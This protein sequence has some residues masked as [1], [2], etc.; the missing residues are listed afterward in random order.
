MQNLVSTRTRGRACALAVALVCAAVASATTA[1][2][3]NVEATCSAFP[4]QLTRVQGEPGSIGLSIT[5]TNRTS[6]NVT[7]TTTTVDPTFGGGGSFDTVLA[8]GGLG[9][10]LSFVVQTESLPA[11]TG[12]ITV[13][14][15]SSATGATILNSC[16]YTFT[17]LPAGTDSDGD[18]LF[19]SWETSG[20]DVDLN[21]SIDVPLPGANPQ[22]RDLYVEVDCL[23]SDA[24]SNGSLGDAVDHSHCPVEGAI[25]DV[26]QGFANAPVSN[27]DGTRGVQLHVDTGALYGAGVIKTVNGTGGVVGTYGDLGG[28]GSQIPEAGNEIIDFDGATGDPGTSIYT[29]KAANFDARRDAVYRYVIF[30]HQTNG[31]AATFDCTSGWAEGIPGNDCFVTLGGTRDTAGAACW[32]TDANGFSVG[33]RAEQAGTFMHE[34]GHIIG[35]GH[36]GGDGV[37]TKPNYLS[38]MNY[39]S[40]MCSVAA[41]PGAGLPGGCDYSRI[42]LPDLN[43]SSLDECAGIGPVLGLGPVDWNGDM[44]RQGVTCPAPSLMT[45]IPPIDINGDDVCV[46]PGPNGTLETT[47]N[48]ADVTSGTSILDGN[49]F[50]CNTMA[51]GDDEQVNALNATQP[52]PLTGFD[53]WNNLF[54]A[55]R[56]VPVY[57]AG[58]SA[59]VAEEADPA[60]IERA[61]TELAAMTEPMV[62]VVKTGPA[63]GSPGEVLTYTL[64]I[65]NTGHG[66]AIDTVLTDTLPD[67][68]TVDF[69]IGTLPAGGEVVKTVT[70]KVPVNRGPGLLLN[71]AAASFTDLAATGG[72]AEG[73]ASTDVVAP[74]NVVVSQVVGK[75]P[76][77]S[78]LRVSGAFLTFPPGDVFSTADGVSVRVRDVF[79]LDQQQTWAPGDCRAGER[80][81]FLCRTPDRSATARFTPLP[82]APGQYKFEIELRRRTITAPFIGPLQVDLTHDLTLHRR[83]TIDECKPTIGSTFL[84]RTL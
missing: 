36:G 57:T 61:R 44:A 11:G 19:D 69:A 42:D 27:P 31:R 2:A 21:G 7:F 20:V 14:L 13:Q 65:R 17:I 29:L 77:R 71:T 34:F 40:Q 80:G 50:K 49:D 51:T 8:G 45:N 35:L 15:T 58:I 55:F 68:T 33:S 66:P 46:G 22:R 48:A 5:F 4:T 63:E 84:C 62:S 79:N 78:R 6:G 24:N 70:Y 82:H 32:T 54:Y 37:N 75:G 83:G 9:R 10:S 30:G 67:G 64:T 60:T 47:A 72:S 81:K 28:G 3:Q 25:R 23:V 56:T 39:A 41:V 43:E 18:S 16:A 76:G 73:S 26:V 74:L 59:P 53:D 38:V 1:H 12:T 52:E